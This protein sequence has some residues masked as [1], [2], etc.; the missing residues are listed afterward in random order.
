MPVIQFEDPRKPRQLN[1]TFDPH[2]RADYDRAA[3]LVMAASRRVRDL[4]V[5]MDATRVGSCDEGKFRT[6]GHE[7]MCQ[8]LKSVPRILNGLKSVPR[9][10]DGLKSVPRRGVSE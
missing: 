10:F 9:V 2:H 6:A 7:R 8:G 3:A 1:L 5:T 4:P